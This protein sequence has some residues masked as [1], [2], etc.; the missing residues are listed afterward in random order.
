MNNEII[1]LSF[2][3]EAVIV[4]NGDFPTHRIP[5]GLLERSLFTVCC[6]GAANS[7]LDSGRVP[8]RIVGDGD[9]LR[10]AYKEEYARILRLNP[11]QETNDQTKAVSYLRAKGMRSVAI[12][13]ATGKREDH[14]MGNISLLAEYGGMGMEARIYTDYGVFIPASG[15]CRFRCEPGCQVSVFSLGT[16]GMTSEGLVYPLYDFTRWWQ[17]TLNEVAESPF[18]IRC[19][20]DYIVFINYPDSAT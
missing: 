1:D 20:G 16:E 10:P 17:G 5:L 8:D 12:I 3:P 7:F 6:D 13:G 2:S 9:S 14:T 19:K 4:G 18:T 11:D 15:D